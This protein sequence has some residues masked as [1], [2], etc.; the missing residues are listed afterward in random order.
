VFVVVTPFGDGD[1]LVHVLVYIMAFGGCVP[2]VLVA[3][4]T[5]LWRRSRWWR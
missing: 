3:D 1:P 4:T 5:S 2:L